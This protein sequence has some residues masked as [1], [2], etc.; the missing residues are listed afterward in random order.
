MQSVIS[1]PA[2]VAE[3]IASADAREAIDLAPAGVEQVIARSQQQTSIERL[4]IYAGAYYAR[5]LECLRAEYPIMAQAMGAELFDEFAVEYLRRYPSQSYTLNEL[6]SRFAQFLAETRPNS[7]D[8][9]DSWLDFLVDLATLEWCFSEVFDGPGAENQPLLSAAE[10]KELSP[11]AWAAARLVPVPCLRILQLDFPVQTYYR[12]IR[13]GGEPPPPDR[14]PTWLAISRRN[15]VVR[16]FTLA[17]EEAQI[18][19]AIVAGRT[20]GEALAQV[21]PPAEVDSF[22]ADLERW[23][24]QWTAEGLFSA[25]LLPSS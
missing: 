1:N 3:G 17:P 24:Q 22:A 13:A 6:G 21:S 10:L 16:H 2:G 15:Y 11:D 7:P 12:A 5:L 25:V 8:E 14:A 23:F 4:E 19:Q 20:I 9:D 18:L